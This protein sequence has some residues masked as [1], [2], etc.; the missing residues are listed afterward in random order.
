MSKF[1]V[2]GIPRFG[3]NV[4]APFVK[5]FLLLFC[6]IC[7][8][9]KDDCVEEDKIDADADADFNFSIFVCCCCC[10]LFS[11]SIFV[12]RFNKLKLSNLFVVTPL[13]TVE[14]EIVG[15]FEFLVLLLLSI[16]KHDSVLFI[17][18]FNF[19]SFYNII[20]SFNFNDDFF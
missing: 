18:F 8:K 1:V 3:Q 9:S 12:L 2:E 11:F 4:F 15:K 14:F 17:F 19:F 5:K 6:C 7:V 16:K 10:C 20:F 13:D